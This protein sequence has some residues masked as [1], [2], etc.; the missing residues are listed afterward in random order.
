MAPDVPT[1]PRR[2]GLRSRVTATFAL[3]SALLSLL[4]SSATYVLVR[5][6]AVQRRE[7]IIENV[8]FSNAR[9]VRQQLLTDLGTGRVGNTVYTDF[10]QRSPVDGTAVLRY[11]GRTF[12]T[13]S[14]FLDGTFD[15]EFDIPTALATAV[16]D[17]RTVVQR[18][19][20]K[21]V[22]VLVVGVPLRLTADAAAPAAPSADATGGDVAWAEYYELASL[23]D[24]EGLLDTLLVALVAVGVSTTLT[25]LVVGRR[26]SRRVLAPL[27]DV[28]NA[29]RALA[30]MSADATLPPTG[31]PDLA[32]L[33]SSFN[34]TVAALQERIERD[35]RFASDVS[36][37]LRSPLTTL[38][39]SI[40]VLQRH[41]AE[42]PEPAQ[43]AVALLGAEFERF[44]Q[45]VG[46]LL[47]ISRFDA[48]AQH[49][50]RSPLV[51]GEFLRQAARFTCPDGTP[52]VIDAD[53]EEAVI[54]ADKRR[55]VQVLSNL[56][57]NAARYA[58]G[59]TELTVSRA[60][61]GVELAVLDRGPGVPPAERL[62]IFDRFSRGVT[63]GNR[64]NDQGTG[65]GL[66]LVSE[67]VRLH[68]GTV[69]VEDRP[70]G[71]PGACFIVFL[72]ANPV[73]I[74]DSDEDFEAAGIGAEP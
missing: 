20:L 64:G 39:N 69:R 24:V 16:A 18:V 59:V 57:Q 67:H 58:D 10:L 37:E 13:S 17:Q 11:G 8:A 5:G 50:E 74:Y 12:Y 32:P 15:P 51:L 56:A 9:L 60:R 68:G 72:P 3:L 22:P 44:Q 1:R 6:N 30:T 31:D 41:E 65:L 25:G 61:G 38:T 28:N 27:E 63:A 35:G 43:R 36:H 19:R 42:L 45:L 71:E 46:D 47:E 70:D 23:G 29:V 49:L 54:M 26:V 73:S 55:L 2:I 48:G 34:D 7:A 52:V 40:A 4:L 14:S 21:G 62:R 53:L 33:V 66:A